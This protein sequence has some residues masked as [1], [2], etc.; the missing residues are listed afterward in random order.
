MS[1]DF[2]FERKVV[3]YE[4][5]DESVVSEEEED[6]SMDDWFKGTNSFS[7]FGSSVLLP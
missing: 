2:N 3:K 1:G 7:D 5:D 4:S 6:Y